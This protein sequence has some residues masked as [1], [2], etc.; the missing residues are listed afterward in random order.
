MELLN[1]LLIKTLEIFKILID[2]LQKVNTNL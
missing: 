2:A 1:Q